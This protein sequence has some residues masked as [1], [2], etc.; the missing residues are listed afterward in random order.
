[1]SLALKI[2]DDSSQVKGFVYFDAV[3]AFN[4]DITGKVTSHPIETGTNISDHFINDNPKFTIKGIISDVDI[5]GTSSLIEV[6]DGSP[7]NSRERP[8]TP[9]IKEQE[10]TY[11]FLPSA[12]KQFFERT[13]VE[14]EGPDSTPS[15][16]P[17]VDAIFRQLMD[18]VYYNQA[19]R[20]WRNSSTTVVLYEM[21]G[22]N[23]VNAHTDLIITS[24]SVEET[25]DTGDALTVS[26]TL[27]KVRFA[28]LQSTDIPSKVSR[29]NRGK[30]SGTTLKGK[31]TTETGASDSS[32]ASA[33]KSVR[34]TEVTRESQANLNNIQR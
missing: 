17:S 19:D 20:R 31:P 29:A 14:V 28:S 7:I 18:G 24:Y 26:M 33:P 32:S 2:G 16:I 34:W 21:D 25:A 15:A 23:F 12:A 5:T 1:M 11:R 22:A 27:E 3:T 4:K 6:E 13:E 9:V 30:V 10:D 8:V